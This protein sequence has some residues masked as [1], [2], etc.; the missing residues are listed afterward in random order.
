M[1]QELTLYPSKRK[2]L[3]LLILSLVFTGIGLAM[4][5]SGERT[6]WFVFG[7]FG[8]CSAVFVISMLPGASYLRLKSE[9]YDIC[10]LF[11]THSVK[12]R[13]IG[14]L[15]VGTISGNKMVVFDYSP[16]YTEHVSSRQLAKNLTGFEGALY[17]TFG[18]STE[19]LAGVMNEWRTTARPC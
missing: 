2:L 17:N 19:E 10:S 9:G 11:K 12:W 13:D 4:L 1:K 16:N 3:L 6:G 15:T 8:L 5:V 18:M 7:F 14:P